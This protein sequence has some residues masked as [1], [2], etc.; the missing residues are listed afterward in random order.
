MEKI[1]NTG[2][3]SWLGWFYRGLLIV[4]VL[5]LIGRLFDLQVIRGSYYR[6][7]AE[8]NRIRE[9]SISAPRGVIYAR[10][11]EALVGN[12]E[13]KKKVI[14]DLVEGYQKTEFIENALEDEIIVEPERDYKLGSAFAHVSGYL[15]SI[16][17]GELGKVRPECIEKGEYV[18]DSMVGRTG[19]EQYYECRLAGINGEELVEVDA[20]GKKVRTLG[21]KNPIPGVDLQTTIDYSL[22]K[23]LENLFP[24]DE[25]GDLADY[26][27][28][29]VVTDTEGG[30]LAM[31]SAPS[32]DPN[33]LT[34]GNS[35]KVSGILSDE[36]LPLFNR[37]FGGIYQPGSVYKPVIS[38]AALEEGVIDSDFT[39]EDTG[40]I[41]IKTLYGDFSYSNWYLTQYGKVEGEIAL[42]KAI[43]RSTDTFFYK[44]GELTGIDKIVK[45]SEKF[46]LGVESGIDLPGELSGLVPSPEWKKNVKGERWFLGNTYQFA[47]GQSDLGV[48]PLQQNGVTSVIA[49]GGKLC[50]PYLVGE[51]K[52]VDLGISK[53]NIDLV[54]QG[55]IEACSDGG[56]GYTFFDSPIPVAC[57]TGT[58]QTGD[59]E[60]THAWFTFFAPAPVGDY[61]GRKPEI[62]VTVLVEK[63]GEGSRVAGPI[64]RRIYDKWFGLGND[65]SEAKNVDKEVFDEND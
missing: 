7:L 12:K 18:F 14:F 20:S 15:G 62:V 65:L 3:Q 17:E 27:G 32:Y 59:G 58:A 33:D 4:G 55:M 11:G 47:I 37:I 38:I 29:V 64:A 41:L 45:W 8:G 10:G 57:K 49:S 26:T 35:E 43:A 53:E 48:T 40:Q 13:I 63:A 39:Y 31:Y 54:T 61:A 6:E 52:C 28:A 5:V 46:G 42:P 1:S 56:T 30:V 36:K 44:I 19:L 9:I 2:S 34:S 23:E 60:T 22:Q 25:K 21:Q 16:V 51:S 24:Y 50:K